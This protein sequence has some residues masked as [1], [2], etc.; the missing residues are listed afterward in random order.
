MFGCQAA[1]PALRQACLFC[2]FTG[3]Y[4]RIDAS[5]C[6]CEESSQGMVF[7]LRASRVALKIAEIKG[8][9]EF[10]P[11]VKKIRSL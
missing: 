3:M 11:I 1:H 10:F 5:G 2:R 4:G 9:C 8:V 6:S 7:E